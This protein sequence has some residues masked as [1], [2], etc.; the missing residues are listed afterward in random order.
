[1]AKAKGLTPMMRQYREIKDS[2]KEY[3]LLYRLGDFYEMFFEDAILASSELDIVL[4]GRECGLDEKAPMCGVPYHSVDAYI[5]R[6]VQKGH[7]VAI[8][9]QVE[10]P[11][12]AK[13]IVKRDIVRLITPGTVTDSDMLEGD[14][15]S[16][17]AAIVR[18]EGFVSFCYADASTGEFSAGRYTLEGKMC[19]EIG[20]IA[21]REMLHFDWEVSDGILDICKKS[22]TLLTAVDG[23]RELYAKAFFDRYGSDYGDRHDMEYED[24]IAAGLIINYLMDSQ[25]SSDI[26]LS[27]LS[28]MGGTKTLSIDFATKRN[29]ELTASLLT[30]D[31]KGSLLSVLD[32][33]KTAAGARFLRSEVERPL[34]DAVKIKERVSAVA[35]LK[36]GEDERQS[37]R[38]ALASFCDLERYVTKAVYKS[39]NARELVAMGET[40]S[41]VP[42]VKEI[43][44]SMDCPLIWELAGELD[45]LPELA[46]RIK[47][48]F[49]DDLPTTIREG[50]MIKKG[51]DE[52]ADY[53]RD[54][55]EGG[56]GRIVAIEQAER[57]KSGIKTLKISFNK[58]FGYYIDISNSHRDKVPEHYI[59]KQTLVNSERYITPELKELEGEVLSAGDRLKALEYEIFAAVRDQAATCAGRIS[60]TARIIAEV[61]FLAS[62]AEVAQKYRYCRPEIDEGEDIIIEEGRHPVVERMGGDLFVPNDT[63]LNITRDRLAI[64]TGP[65]MA[66][67]STYMRQTALIII[68]AQMGSFVPARSAR[69]GIVDKVFTRVGA[70]DNL[71]GGQS[72]FMIEMSETAHILKN[73]TK[74]S[75]II[76][77]EIG[78]GTSTFDGMSIARAV[79]EFVADK[80]EIGARTLF[81]THYHEL[82]ELEGLVE[83]VVN[84]NVAVK[85]RGDEITFLRKIIRG[86]A[87]DSYGIQVA[88]LAG[89][90][91][92]VTDKAKEVLGELEA[93]RRDIAP[94]QMSFGAPRECPEVAEDESLAEVKTA[95]LRLDVTALTPIEA[96]NE[97]YKLQ[98]RVEEMQ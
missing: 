21:P 59:R 96:M 80:G 19:D 66:G 1:M 16:Y 14:K 78:R 49:G 39:A 68:M 81:A 53:L 24:C 9:E 98:K 31:K 34:F 7:K 10:D 54:L 51:F 69:I 92:A 26:R 88:M 43:L 84:Y 61:D 85:K 58:V 89:V 29:L 65:N 76:F 57:E 95:L 44:L 8:C 48:T 91:Q 64:I 94:V 55:Y 22:S 87:D 42:R 41:L 67:K 63:R 40:L 30:G 77:D 71:A 79:L 3:I 62:L 90:P 28:F 2:N 73:A 4:T 5:A 60:K 11:K 97:L 70:S 93:G 17:L 25:R 12:D 56:R 33:T 38:D 83:G 46:E 86:A 47:A 82:T 18:G 75:F 37:L 23:G 35:T 50:G 32:M 15:N 36:D 52:N 72:T 13:G 27:E 45:G 74:R 20:R 6:L